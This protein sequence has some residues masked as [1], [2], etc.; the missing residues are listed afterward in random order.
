MMRMKPQLLGYVETTLEPKLKLLEDFGFVDQNLVKLL[1]ENPYILCNS[2]ENS[3]FPMMEFLKNVF[4]SQDV[5][6]KALL[7]APRLLSFG[8]EKTLKPSLAF[9]EGWGFSGTKLVSFLKVTSALLSRTSLTLAHL[10]LIQK[11]GAE[12][13]STVF[14]YIVGIVAMRRMET[15]EEKIENLKLCGLSEEETWQLLG[16]SPVVLS[17]SKES[18]SE[19]MNFLVNNTELPASYV[20]KHPSFLRIHVEEV[21]KPRFLVWQKIKSINGY[22]LPLLM[23]LSMPETRFVN[24]IIKGHPES[25]ILWTI[26]ENAISNASNRSKSS[27]KDN[28]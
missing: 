1:K 18:V 11:I 13:E 20:L 2:L 17:F 9:W 25:K 16:A 15:L 28:F 19:K 14:R 26:Y 12:K 27:T 23:V 8:L 5:L 7:K 3:L 24:S 22:E 4:Q 21:M 6:V 10:D